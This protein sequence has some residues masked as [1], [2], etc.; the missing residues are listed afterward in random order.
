MQCKRKLQVIRV[1]IEWKTFILI[2]N[3]FL[4]GI[5]YSVLFVM[6]FGHCRHNSLKNE[7]IRRGLLICEKKSPDEL[8]HYN[9]ELFANSWPRQ[10][11]VHY[12][13]HYM[14]K[15]SLNR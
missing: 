7:L 2:S 8:R 4:F 14:T 12:S 5:F 10:L 3:S 15:I 1:V 6:F 11:L 9:V 13:A